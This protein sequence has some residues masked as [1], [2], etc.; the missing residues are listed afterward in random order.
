MTDS[1]AKVICLMGPTASGKTHL[2]IELAKQLPVDLISVDSAM[3]YRGL[4]IGTAKPTLAERQKI[5]HQLIDIRDP[6]EPYSAGQFYQD[7]LVA[8]EHS[9]QNNRIPL[10]V[11]GTML[12]FHVLQKGFSDLPSADEQVREKLRLQ[13]ETEGWQALYEQLQKIDPAAAA[14]IK[15]T[16]TQRIQRALEVFYL[17][18]QTLSDLR[19]SQKLSSLPFHFI[20]IICAPSNRQLLHE[21]IA[22]RFSQ[23]L[24]Q[25]L[26]EEVKKL[27]ERGD[28]NPDL[29]ALRTVGYRQIWGY[30]AGEYDY[31]TMQQK[32]IAATRQLAKRQLTWLRQWKDAQWFNSESPNVSS[33]ILKFLHDKLLHASR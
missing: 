7:V 18:G 32:A 22:Q 8:I 4:D 29:P 11:G 28:L 15:P 20:N 33:E 30:L 16:D 27:Y 1:T 5:P 9:H 26:I 21:R 24:A 12:Y 17:T 2:A 6:S 23:M 14:Q 19:H 13:A 31:E 10:L 3:V 25:G